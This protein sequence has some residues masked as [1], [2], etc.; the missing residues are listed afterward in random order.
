[1]TAPTLESLASQWRAAKAAEE[2]A[3]KERAALEWAIISQ[4]GCHEEGSQTVDAGEW[5]IRVTGKLTRKLDSDAWER[6]VDAVPEALRPVSYEPKLDLKG[7]RYLQNNEP[8]I[9]RTVAQAIETKP[10]KPSVEVK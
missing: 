9:Y 8:D 3:R 2:S 10:A 6:I 7:L 1:M 5:K 4:T